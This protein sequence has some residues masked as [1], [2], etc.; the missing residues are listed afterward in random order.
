MEIIKEYWSCVCDFDSFMQ[1]RYDK[2]EGKPIPPKCVVCDREMIK[3]EP[4]T[5]EEWGEMV[6]LK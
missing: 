6:K 4:H 5:F 3:S 1:R 2:S